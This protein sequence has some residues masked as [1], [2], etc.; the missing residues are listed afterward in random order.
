MPIL[1]FA[2]SI[3]AASR[4]EKGRDTFGCPTFLKPLPQQFLSHLREEA[5]EVTVEDVGAS[6]CRSPR[7]PPARCCSVPCPGVAAAARHGLPWTR[8]ARAKGGNQATADVLRAEG[9]GFFSPATG[10]PTGVKHHQF[11]HVPL[12]KLS[13]N[14]L[15]QCLLPLLRLCQRTCHQHLHW[16][17]FL[18]LRCGPNTT[19]MVDVKAHILT[20]AH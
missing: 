2:F 5:P 7:P 1:N 3:N 14:D 12:H 13:P 10:D 16:E 19:I 20:H 11:D 15:E 8:A 6:S 17:A 4:K 18:D 9:D